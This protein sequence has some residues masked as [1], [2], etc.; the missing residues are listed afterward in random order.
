MRWGSILLL[1][2]FGIA[3]S[4]SAQG[5]ETDYFT[6]D[7][8]IGQGIF[9]EVSIPCPAIQGVP[10]ATDCKRQMSTWTVKHDTNDTPGAL[11]LEVLVF[12]S[13]YDPQTGNR[14]YYN[15]GQPEEVFMMLDM[16]AFSSRMPHVCRYDAYNF[17]LGRADGVQGWEYVQFSGVFNQGVCSLPEAP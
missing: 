9:P 12:D 6:D 5:D 8:K 17:D 13:Y 1:V 7:M 3:I 14:G 10:L 4:G 15:V 16:M 2:F 11:I